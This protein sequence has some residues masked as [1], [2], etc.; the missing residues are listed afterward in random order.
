MRGRPAEPTLGEAGSKAA[1]ESHGDHAGGPGRPQSPR[2]GAHRRPGGEHVVDQ[3]DAARGMPVGSIRGGCPSR[4]ARLRPTCRRAPRR[5]NRAPGS[6]QALGQRRRQLPGGIEPPAPQPRARRR[7]RHHRPAQHVRRRQPLDP[8]RHQVRDRQQPPEL[9]RRNQLRATPSMRRRRPSPI[10]P[11]RPVPQQ[12]LR[13]PNRRAQRVQTTASGRQD[14]RKPHTTAEQ[15]RG[16]RLHDLH[17]RSSW[18]S[19]CVARTLPIP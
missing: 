12:R 13:V 1:G 3:E 14:D 8:V 19:A 11:R 9:Q 2:T 15:R 17:R 6:V 10:E 18:H 4:S 16:E 5:T 7:H